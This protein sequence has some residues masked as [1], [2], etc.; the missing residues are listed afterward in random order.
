MGSLRQTTLPQGYTNSPTEFQRR[1]TH[2]VGPMIPN[3]ADVFIDDCALKGPKNY[4]GHETTQENAHVRCFVWEYAH[5]LQELLARIQESGATVSGTKMILA[6]PRLSML[7]AVVSIDGMHTS[8]E[9]TAKISKWPSCKNPS[10]VRGFLGTV[11]VVRRWIKD[12]AKIA[13]PLT[14]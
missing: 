7:G 12:F 13:K 10:E 6:T 3:K 9:V 14:Q 11:G 2:M 5:N 8:H 4:Y 1:T